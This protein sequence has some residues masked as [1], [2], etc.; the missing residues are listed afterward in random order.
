MRLVVRPV[1][2]TGQFLG[3]GHPY[4]SG[5]LFFKAVH[6]RMQTVTRFMTVMGLCKLL[7]RAHSRFPFFVIRP[8]GGFMSIPHALHVQHIAP[9]NQ[10]MRSFGHIILHGSNPTPCPGFKLDLLSL[11][12]HTI[13]Y[14]V[15]QIH[16]SCTCM[17]KGG[18]CGL[19]MHM[20]LRLRGSF[21]R[22][23]QTGTRREVA[24][25]Q[26]CFRFEIMILAVVVNAVV[27]GVDKGKRDCLSQR[28][29]QYTF[30]IILISSSCPLC[31][32]LLFVTVGA[33]RPLPH[34]TVG[35]F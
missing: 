34:R 27:C 30:C 35:F 24:K 6:S 23:H 29:H 7:R 17:W 3:S 2:S 10:F 33:I 12:T 19:A 8:P 5:H 15:Q 25:V 11:W 22:A 32:S 13:I 18:D 1:F 20:G 26:G 14:L 21:P 4:S 28:C 9:E 31:I 16:L